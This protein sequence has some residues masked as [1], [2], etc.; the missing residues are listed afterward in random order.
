MES[1]NIFIFF[2]ENS[3]NYLIINYIIANYKPWKVIPLSWLLNKKKYE[4][5]EETCR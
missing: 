5:K 3:Y 1:K 2:P 4:N